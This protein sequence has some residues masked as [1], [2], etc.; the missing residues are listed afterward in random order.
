MGGMVYGPLNPE[1]HSCSCRLE[2]PGTLLPIF[3]FCFPLSAFRF[4]PSAFRF[5]LSAFRFQLSAFSLPLSAF[6]LLLSA[7]RFQLFAFR[8]RFQLFAFRFLLSVQP[9]LCN[10]V[11]AF[12]Q[13]TY[14]QY[15]LLCCTD[16]PAIPVISLQGRGRALRRY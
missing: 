4:Q 8:F 11:H 9:V 15:I 6:R 1:S 5:Q 7:F 16:I 12:S 3:S 2:P 10:F 14:H 13:I